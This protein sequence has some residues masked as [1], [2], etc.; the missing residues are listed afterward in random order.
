MCQIAA[1]AL[2]FFLLMLIWYLINFIELEVF[3]FTHGCHHFTLGNFAQ[4]EE[5]GF[6]LAVRLYF[7]CFD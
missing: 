1:D 6:E 2:L 4:P 3:T 7:F 5:F